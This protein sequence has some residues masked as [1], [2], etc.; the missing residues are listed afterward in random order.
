[1]SL[2][3]IGLLVAYGIL[4]TNYKLVLDAERRLPASKL[5]LIPEVRDTSTARVLGLRVE[6]LGYE[7]VRNANGYLHRVSS[8][9]SFAPHP[10]SINDGMHSTYL[11]WSSLDGGGKL[12]TFPDKAFL[13]ILVVKQPYMG[14]GLVAVLDDRSQ[15]EY[16]LEEGRPYFFEVVVA[17]DNCPRAGGMYRVNF[18]EAPHAK[19]DGYGTPDPVGAAV[20]QLRDLYS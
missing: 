2:L 1:L 5:M 15:S 4:K 8:S 14:T 11:R 10:K 20:L 3:P 19:R 9:E 13:E 16:V 18:F 17:S 7:A 6:Q 12:C